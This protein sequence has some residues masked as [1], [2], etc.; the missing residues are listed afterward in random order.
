[1]IDDY[2]FNRAARKGQRVRT[3]D[4]HGRTYEGVAVVRGYDTQIRTDTGETI[5]VWPHAC[6]PVKTR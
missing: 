5:A 3:T 4:D 1:L 6:N 2:D